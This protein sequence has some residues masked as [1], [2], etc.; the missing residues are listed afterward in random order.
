MTVKTITA[1]YDRY[2]N[3]R[4]TIS[5]LEAA[6][7]STDTISV[8]ANNSS[9]RL[10]AARTAPGTEAAAGAGA[11]ASLGT[12]LGGGAGLLA[13]L[14]MLAIPGVG[15]VV[16]AGWLVATAVGA[17]AG[18]GVGGA[19]GG[20]IGSMISAGV[21]KENA[22]IYAE[23][24]RRGGTLVTVRVDETDESK[25]EAIMRKHDPVDPA[26]RGKAYRENGW[27]SF[28]ANGAPY[29]APEIEREQARYR[30]ATPVV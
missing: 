17:A 5:D 24:V 7:I 6:K 21:L 29:G 27:T 22:E 10:A 15:P 2:E 13:G 25:V 12:V 1:L 14:G 20:V 9:G 23:G 30:V 11:G 18:A 8:I 3:A 19:S 4:D 16:A 26:K 28:N